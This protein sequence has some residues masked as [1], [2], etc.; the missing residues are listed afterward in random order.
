MFEAALGILPLGDAPP[1]VPSIGRLKILERPNRD[2]AR[3]TRAVERL[4][5]RPE[6]QSRVLA[7]ALNFF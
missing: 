7:R 1:F 5:H 6:L 3:A 4:Q 2:K